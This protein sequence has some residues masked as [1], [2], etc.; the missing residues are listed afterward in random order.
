MEEMELAIKAGTS[1]AVQIWMNWM[2]SVFAATL[3]FAWKHKAARIILGVFVLTVP[4]AL[5][6]FNLSHSIHLI[7]IAHILAWG[8]L[9]FYLVKFE[10]KSD[11]FQL[12]SP[13]GI[14]MILLLATIAIS[15]AFDVRDVTL[16]LL[17]MK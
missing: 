17:G 4:I 8:P 3:L 10:L 5:L 16:V 2:L 6:V 7:G 15:L 13:Y 12:K 9:A 11:S 14:W 1:P